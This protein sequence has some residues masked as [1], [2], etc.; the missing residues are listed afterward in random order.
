MSNK[1]R[2]RLLSFLSIYTTLYVVL[3]FVGNMIPFFNMP[4][5]GTIELELIAVFLASYHMGW[6]V[7]GIVAILAWLVSFVLGAPMWFVHPMQ[8]L[9]DYVLPLLAC[10]F[11]SILWPFGR[12]NRK[13]WLG[14]SVVV[15]VLA[16]VGILM[17]FPSGIATWIGAL[18]VMAGVFAFNYWYM[19]RETEFGIVL[20][21][22][23]KY[24]FTVIS[25]AYYWADGVAAG[26]LP[27]WTFSLSYNLG[28]NLV[29][30]VVCVIAVPILMDRVLS[31]FPL[32]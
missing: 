7:G 3:K 24:L 6:K 13:S 27:A 11:A 12:L 1:I 10:G 14:V 2:I 8:I 19:K 9:L 18:A 5:G 28:Y 15:A 17:S 25:G 16:C 31:Q 30:M 21:M 26:S 23:L 4:N 29:T 20:A 22:L 32:K